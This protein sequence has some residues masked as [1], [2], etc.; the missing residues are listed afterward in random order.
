VSDR[1][2]R[3]PLAS[4]AGLLA[5]LA[6]HPGGGTARAAAPA[7]AATP[8]GPAIPER[9]LEG[10][11]W[12]SVGPHR[13]GRVVAVAGVVGQPMVYYFGGT[14]GGIWKTTDAGQRWLPVSDGQI[15]TGS[16]GAV[17]VAPSD[18]NVVY[19][20]MGEGCIRGNVSHG[21]GVYRSRDAGKTWTDAG[22][23]DTRHIGRIQVHPQDPDLV[24]VA[25]LGHAFGPNAERGVFRSRDGGGT[26]QK[27]L[28]V[29]DKTGAI[30]LAMDP[31]NPRVLYAAFWQ[32]LRTP[33]SLESGGPGSALYKS[34]DGGDTWKKLTTGGLPKGPWGRLGVT[35]SAAQ[36]GRVWA[37]IEA[38]EGGVY[39][40]DDAGAT[41]R[42]TN[43]ERK[44]RQRAWYYTHVYADTQSP[45]TVWVLNVGMWRSRDGGRTFEQVRTPH[46]DNHDLWIDPQ[47]S[48]RMVQGNDGG[49]TV[50]FDAGRSWSTIDN[51]PTA[52]MYHVITDRRVPYFLYG[53]Q[54]DN[55]TMAIPSASFVGG[56]DE[57]DWYPVG[58]CE[59]GY[60]APKPDDGQVVFAGCYG[61]QITRYDHRTRQS[62][63]VTVWPE[64][65]MGWGAEGMKYRF[66]WTFPIVL[67]PHDPKILYAAGNRVF[68]SDNEGHSWTP[69]SGDLTRNDPSKLGPS[70]GPITKDN[71]SVEYYGTVFALVESPK[72]PGVLWA[73]SDD[74]LVH[75]SQDGGKSWTNVTPKEMPEWSLISQIDASPHDAGTAYLATTRYKL[76]DFRPYAWVTRDY[77]RTWRRISGNLPETAFVRVVR[78]DPA[79]RGLLFAGTETGL[80]VS[81]DD[82]T[83]W[84]PLRMATPGTATPEPAPLPSPSP[85][86]AASASAAAAEAPAPERDPMAGRLPVVPVTDLVVHGNDLVVATQGRSFWILDDLSPLRQMAAQPPSGRAHLFV[87]APA[88]RMIAGGAPP[89]TG[90]N[91]PAGAVLY[92][93]LERAPNEGE[94]V[95]IEVL[96]SAGALVRRLSSKADPAQEA[97]ADD[98]DDGPPA[99]R[100]LRL[101]PVAGLNRV[102][103]D[104]RATEATRFKGLIL[105]AGG[106]QG[107]RVPPGTYQV[108]LVADGQTV[109]QPLEVLP[110]PRLG[111]TR[112][113]YARQYALLGKIRETLTRT[114][115]AIVRI[116]SLRDQLKAAADRAKAAGDDGALGKAAE[117]LTKSLTA[118]EE[119]LY[120]TK[121]Q[122]NQDPLN[123]PIRLNNKLSALAGVVARAD[124]A[125]TEQAEAVFADLAQRI[126][127]Q[128]DRLQAIVDTD[129]PAFNRLVRERDVPAI[130]VS[131]TKR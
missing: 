114:H 81:T 129:V 63:D 88:S 15:G 68:R 117:A 35:A 84:Q 82:G 55:T 17:A 86:P 73:G 125:P 71:T 74:G 92:Y 59:S 110:D 27:V 2:R 44:L 28:F 41:W 34:T 1:P 113:D 78:E 29:D 127:V 13:G 8:A 95:A 30:D 57:A 5:L 36:A 98:D 70:G 103:W 21:D 25:A 37:V 43:S 109:V 22:L 49:A 80:Y 75:V 131:G 47:D 105:W 66:Q 61:G 115:D 4:F 123:Y 24:Y 121:N 51:Q 101:R 76:D 56:I 97:P 89:G 67:S 31:A 19:A 26:W 111:T 107:P 54:Q 3:W 96:D 45:E 64:N 40:S 50:T 122:S 18:A 102:V 91:P 62:R 14:G 93:A 12:R 38:E 16:V 77:G 120:Q 32:V 20:G 106:T 9:Q 119:E 69:I 83:R 53:A 100:P 104:L 58:G 108:R 128:L 79:R 72:T 7:R 39:R 46:G 116:R 60:I 112:E 85:S 99:A 11:T 10:L 23:R 52:Q 65:P 6:L 130:L 42:R 33:W 118:V 124:A 90:Q 94:E 87:P 48:R 126:Q